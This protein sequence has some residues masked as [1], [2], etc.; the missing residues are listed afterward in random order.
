ME[1]PPFLSHVH[2]ITLNIWH[3]AKENAEQWHDYFCLVYRHRMKSFCRTNHL[4][5]FLPNFVVTKSKTK[6]C[7]LL[8]W[9]VKGLF[10]LAALA[11]LV[12]A[13]VSDF[14]LLQPMELCSPLCL[15][16]AGWAH[17]FPTLAKNKRLA[18]CSVRQP[19]HLPRV[20]G[21]S[22]CRSDWRYL[23]WKHKV[24][25]KQTKLVQ[26]RNVSQRTERLIIH[27][28]TWTESLAEDHR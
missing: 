17:S 10:D 15:R 8:V 24:Q 9:D 6:W 7:N 1:S 5:S 3:A 27:H 21:L 12:R 18:A 28:R 20:S 4:Y 19:Q 16:S 13:A 14:W 2:T 25:Y 11:E 26:M 23:K 22:K